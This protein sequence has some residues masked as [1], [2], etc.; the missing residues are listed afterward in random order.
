M[1]QDAAKIPKPPYKIKGKEKAGPASFWPLPAPFTST[2]D[3]LEMLPP[4]VEEDTLQKMLLP[5]AE[6]DTLQDLPDPQDMLPR[7]GP[8]KPYPP[9]R[10]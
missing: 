9:T 8:F 3:T 1:T 7:P 4:R 2:G 10:P 6:E 5:R